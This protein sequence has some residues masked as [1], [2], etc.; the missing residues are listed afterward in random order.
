[1]TGAAAIRANQ[2]AAPN[3]KE[4]DGTC[5]QASALRRMHINAYWKYMSIRALH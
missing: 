5:V 3:Q 4:H 1:M 2:V